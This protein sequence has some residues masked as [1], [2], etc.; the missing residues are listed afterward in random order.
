MYVRKILGDLSESREQVTITVEINGSFFF[1]L[2]IFAFRQFSSNEL[3][4]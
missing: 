3:H 2:R 4:S 1:D